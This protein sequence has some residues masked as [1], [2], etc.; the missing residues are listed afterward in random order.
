MDGVTR[1]PH[2]VVRVVNR[3][4][5][6][7]HRRRPRAVI[8]TVGRVNRLTAG[9]GVSLRH[10]LL[11]ARVVSQE[12]RVL[13]HQVPMTM[14]GEAEVVMH[15]VAL[16]HRHH[17]LQARVVNLVVDHQAKVENLGAA[18]L[19]QVTTPVAGMD[20][21]NLTAVGGVHLLRHPQARVV[22]P[23]PRA[24]S[25]SLARALHQAVAS[26]YGSVVGVVLGPIVHRLLQA[27][28]VNL[29]VDHQARAVR[30]LAVQE[31]MMVGAL[32]QMTVPRLMTP[33]GLMGG[34]KVVMQDG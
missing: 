15:G 25:Q 2:Q 22:S 32:R 12:A 28:V 9:D 23:D 18:L 8:G 10:P 14:V 21:A 1:R 20:G 33:G 26:G 6:V 5:R 4:A 30:V 13:L 24:P 3:E 34:L 19:P 11:Q 27:R 7:L 29:V 17:L 31:T 16:G